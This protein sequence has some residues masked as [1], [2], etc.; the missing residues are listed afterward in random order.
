MPHSQ[1]RKLRC[2]L[3]KLV[4]ASHST[5]HPSRRA[6]WPRTVLP[7]SR[8]RLPDRLC[9]FTG[10]FTVGL[11]PHAVLNTAVPLNLFTEPTRTTDKG[12]VPGRGSQHLTGAP[13]RAPS[14]REERPP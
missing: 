10:E 5:R 1:M 7:W 2:S 3:F 12:R 11:Q 4:L 9:T 13:E 8:A 6:S 14:P